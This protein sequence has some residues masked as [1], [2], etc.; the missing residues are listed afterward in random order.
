MD[1]LDAVQAVMELNVAV[2]DLAALTDT[3]QVEE[4]PVHAP[5]QPAN[6]EPEAATAFKVT[7]L[8]DV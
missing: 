2:T 1:I 5:P 7:L 3:I 8:P 6:V 4:V